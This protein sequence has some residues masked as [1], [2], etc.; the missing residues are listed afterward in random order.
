MD[1]RFA[2]DVEDFRSTVR[3]FL[4]DVMADASRHSDPDD[5]TGLD[6]GF[7][8]E[9]HRQ[10]GARGWFG[11]EGDRR[12]VFECEIGRADAPLVDTATVLAGHAVMTFG[13][14]ELQAW[15]VPRMLAGDVEV[16]IAYTEED[17]GSDL[18]R[19][20][21]RAVPHADGGWALSGR[22]TLVTGAH[23]AHWCLTVAR[24][25]DTTGRAGL[26]MFLV[27]MHAPGVNVERRPTMNGWTLD[28]VIFDSAEVPRAHVL[29]AVGEGWRQMAAAVTGERSGA[30]W[31][32]FAHHVM[33]LIVDHVRKGAGRHDPVVRDLV[34]RCAVELADVDRL[35]R[36]A[37]WAAR[38]GDERTLAPSIVYPAMVKLAATELLQHL[39][40]AATEIAGTAGLL[41]ASPFDP[42]PPPGSAAGGRF[43]WEYLERVH[44]TISV[45][46]N[47]LQRDAIARA[48]L[49]LPGRGT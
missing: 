2:D 10:A 24:T 11:L 35:S 16:C 20:E 1:F 36:R 31:L 33:D 47:E 49:G 37:L 9:V 32:G 28:D 15:L 18:T 12:A 30:F 43:A 34:A 21:C 46:A 6:E 42:D 45:G 19:I 23:K 48:G 13:S 29:G 25:G 17:A 7:E 39:A 22:K 26:T 41:W 38:N 4:G 8:R 3:A 5:L 44:G 27:D 14:D 40:Q